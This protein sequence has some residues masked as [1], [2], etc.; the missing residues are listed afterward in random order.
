MENNNVNNA[1]TG[2]K[3]AKLIW[4]L[5]FVAALLVAAFFIWRHQSVNS[6]Y[7]TLKAEK[8]QMRQEMEKEINDL[9]SEHQQIKT[10]YGH[11]SDSLTMKD[12]LIQANAKEIKQLLNYKWEYRKVKRKLDELRVVARTYVHQMD[13]LY[14][15]NHELVEENKEIKVKY[16]AEKAKNTDLEKDKA[17]LQEKINNSSMLTA[18]GAV[19]KAYHL[20]GNGKERLTTKARRVDV[21]EVCFTLSKNTFLQPGAKDIYVRIA[22]PDKQILTPG[23]AQDYVVDYQGEKIQYSILHTVQYDN[24][25]TDICLR[26]QKKHNKIDMLKGKYKIAIFSDGKEVGHTNIELR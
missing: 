23:I 12:S 5:L 20:K 6:E 10:S 15:V 25:A 4:I 2:G 19:A 22:R 24:E 1:S 16:N 8:E 17:R 14:T 11:L 3:N 13:S 18:Y 7:K 9:M 26:W 21:I